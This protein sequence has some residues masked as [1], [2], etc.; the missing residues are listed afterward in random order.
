MPPFVVAKPEADSNYCLADLCKDSGDEKGDAA[1]LFG[2]AADLYEYAL[3]KDHPRTVD[4]R[5]RA[6]TGG[7]SIPIR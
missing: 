1:R 5:N 4:A 6:S 2:E 7:T 3:G